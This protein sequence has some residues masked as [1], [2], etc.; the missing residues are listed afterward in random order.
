[1]EIIVYTIIVLVISVI[2]HEYSHGWV[3]YR[4]GDSTAKLAGRLTLN[5]ISHLDPIGS[6]FLPLLLVITKANFLI[7]WAKPVP[8]NPHNLRDQ[9]YGDLKVAIGGP[10]SNFIVALIFGL[11]ARF[12]PL[13]SSVKS[14]III[15]YFQ[16]DYNF[17]LNS[18]NG[19]LLASIFILSIIIVFINLLLMIFNLI[20]IP[21]LDGSKIL[22]TFLPYEWKIRFHQIEPYGIFI[23]LFF[24]MFGFFSLI[25][26]PLIFIFQLLIGV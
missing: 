11:V 5:P 15:N 7:G 6:I 22:M 25:W 18:M 17:L 3:A 23:V 21:P 1:M 19:S 14:S 12:T 13:T 16:G 4:L 20:P 24:V 9:K 10:G 8:Y 2:I 26:I